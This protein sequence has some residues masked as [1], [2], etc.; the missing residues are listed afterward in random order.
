[1]SG[2]AICFQK[3]VITWSIAAIR[4]SLVRPSLRRF[5][6]GNA[7]HDPE[8]PQGQHDPGHAEPGPQRKRGAL[9]EL[10]DHDPRPA[11]HGPNYDLH[12]HQPHHRAPHERFV[13]YQEQDNGDYRNRRYEPETFTH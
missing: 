6:R 12:Q 11:G 9:G 4:R 7:E 3:T 1:M 8:Q 5:G 10:G 2:W 13:P